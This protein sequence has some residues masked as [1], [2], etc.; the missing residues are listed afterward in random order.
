M[1]EPT[2][3]VE[4]I[5]PPPT[6]NKHRSKSFCEVG[7]ANFMTNVFAAGK[8]ISMEILVGVG[9]HAKCPVVL[10]R[11]VAFSKNGNVC[12]L[13]TNMHMWV[14]LHWTDSPIFNNPNQREEGT[15]PTRVSSDTAI[16]ARSQ[17]RRFIHSPAAF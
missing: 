11:F 15:S 12:S 7:Y 1:Q 14:K 2:R 8:K 17:R 4:R 6:N 5:H 16:P 10:K 3:G 13:Q 9:M